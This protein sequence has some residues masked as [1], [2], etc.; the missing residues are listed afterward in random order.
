MS[1]RILAAVEEVKTAAKEASKISQAYEAADAEILRL[2]QQNE[3]ATYALREAE[4]KLKGII[5]EETQDV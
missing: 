2:R 1:E 5:Y 4:R 3:V